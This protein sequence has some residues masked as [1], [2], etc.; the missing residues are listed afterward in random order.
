MGVI[1]YKGYEIHAVPCKLAD[2]GL[3]Q[4][5]IQVFKHGFYPIRGCTNGDG[6]RKAFPI[7]RHPEA[8]RFRI[9]LPTPAPLR[10]R[11]GFNHALN[12]D[13]RKIVARRLASWA[14]AQRLFRAI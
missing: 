14:V 8:L 13:T 9:G 11:A 10:K 4:I 3:W 5:S 7:H 2:T 1:Q 6:D 12:P